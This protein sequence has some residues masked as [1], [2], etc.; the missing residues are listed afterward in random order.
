MKR[1]ESRHTIFLLFLI[2]LAG[3]MLF[4]QQPFRFPVWVDSVRVEG[5]EKTRDQVI[6][7]EIPFQL[8]DSL[9]EDDL[10]HIQNRV[11]NLFLFNQVQI[12]MTEKSGK[13]I[14]VI[15]VKETWYI[16]PVPVLFI[17][18]RDWSK[19]SYGF[20]IT[21]YNFRGL[22]EKLSLGGWLGYNPSFFINY[23]NPWLGRKTRLTIGINIFG[24][25]VANRF[26][27]FDEDHLGFGIDLGRRLTLKNSFQ[28]FFNYKRI[29][30]PKEYKDLT[31][32]QT[33]KDIVP[34]YGLNLRHDSRDLIEY[35]MN[36]VLTNWR[37]S[38]TGFTSNQ[39]QFF[40]MELDNRLYRKVLNRLSLGGSNFLNL[41]WGDLPI[42]DN[43]FIGYGQRIRGYW[44]RIFNAQYLMLQN[45][46]A[47]ISIL[48][49]RYAS[50][51]KA[52]YF[53]SFFQGLKYGLSVGF[54][55]DSGIAWDTANQFAIKKF[56]TGYGAGLHF[57]VPY[58][59]VLR[60]DFAIN[61]QGQTQVIFDV[62]A[63]F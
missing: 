48:P 38:K 61:D 41:N 23:T 2:L 9:S 47:R 54:F 31:V 36:G 63:S 58:L 5:N 24:R 18:D 56:F 21:H 57:H 37:F 60:L 39:P 32:S 28:V 42:Y 46:E 62:G 55:M 14:M 50:W 10:I 16:Y 25:K 4:G 7:R 11:Q 26:I 3:N 51:K 44:N 1:N 33:G 12:Y 45:V 34:Q 35:P 29:I 8:P 52:P 20:S 59:L 13:N 17:N 43:V 15:R 53:S 30:F 22:N 6:L 40:R 49:I 27:D 19:W